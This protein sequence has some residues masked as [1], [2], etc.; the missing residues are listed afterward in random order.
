MCPPKCSPREVFSLHRASLSPSH[1]SF[2]PSRHHL[3]QLPP[4]HSAL[5]WEARWWEG[6]GRTCNTKAGVSAK[7]FFP[8]GLRAREEGGRGRWSPFAVAPLP[9]SL[10]CLWQL[11][12][13]EGES[14]FGSW[15]GL[16]KTWALYPASSSITIMHLYPP[17][18]K[19]AFYT[20]SRCLPASC[21]T[22]LPFWDVDV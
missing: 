2:S 18:N 10:P 12:R 7:G 4:W 8:Q 16:A 1:L 3:L 20:H 6:G 17:G 22:S 19:A 11:W 9:G 13:L 21:R 15:L 5:Y 14:P